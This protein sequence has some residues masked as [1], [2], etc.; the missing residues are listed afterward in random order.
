MAEVDNFL[1][2]VSEELET[3]QK[4]SATIRSKMKVLVDKI[5]EYRSN[6]DAMRLALLS[7]QRIS[8]QIQG[9]AESRSVEIMEAAQKESDRILGGIAEQRAQEENRLVEAKRQTTEFL[10]Q[11][12]QI[13]NKQMNFLDSIGEISPTVSPDTPAAATLKTGSEKKTEAQAATHIDDTFRNIEDSVAKL[14]DTQKDPDISVVSELVESFD[15]DGSAKTKP[16]TPISEA[17]TAVKPRFNFE[18]LRFG[19]N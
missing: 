8:S 10:V 19:D 1:A 2:S 12:R 11:M 13:C 9:E 17:N 5:E 6:E 3:A 7:A 18:D 15:S 4:E 16:F 14:T